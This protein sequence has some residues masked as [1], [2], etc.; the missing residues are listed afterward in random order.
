MSAPRERT[1][2][3]SSMSVWGKGDPIMVSKEVR[4]VAISLQCDQC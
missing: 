1:T 2:R 3:S 4:V